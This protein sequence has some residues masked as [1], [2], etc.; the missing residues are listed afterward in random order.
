MITLL[1]KNGLDPFSQLGVFLTITFMV[2]ACI[3]VLFLFNKFDNA[4][5]TVPALWALFGIFMEQRPGSDFEHANPLVMYASLI[6]IALALFFHFA[7][8]KKQRRAK[9]HI[10]R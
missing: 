6:L 1:V 7:I 8:L 9:K 10:N 5:I 4:F 2:L 3:S